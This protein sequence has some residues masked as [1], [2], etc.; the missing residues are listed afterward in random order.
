MASLGRFS[1]ARELRASYD[2]VPYTC[3]GDP[4]QMDVVGCIFPRKPQLQFGMT[5][6]SAFFGLVEE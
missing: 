3:L 6:E 1:D 4:V 5:V 2:C